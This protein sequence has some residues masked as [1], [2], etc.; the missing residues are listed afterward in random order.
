MFNVK[1][2][3]AILETE[4]D[5]IKNK[6]NILSRYFSYVQI[7][8][9]DGKY[10]SEKTWPY[11]E[12]D[13]D[14]NKLSKLGVGFEIDYMAMPNVDD[15]DKWIQVGA[16]R[17][18]LHANASSSNLDLVSTIRS[19]GAEAYLAFQVSDNVSEYSN[20]IKI[21]DGVQCMGIEKIGSQGQP[22]TE[23]VFHLIDTVRGVKQD[24]PISVDGAVSTENIESLI[25]YRVQQV[26]V[27]SALVSGDIESNIEKFK[28]FDN[29]LLG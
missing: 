12:S 6:V 21:C 25:K 13:N 24:I 28:K 9:V 19:K 2:I 18:I 7:D 26:A 29:I 16:S 5:E 27:G 8:V 17:I 23:K 14:F 3:P 4:F 15:I 11:S 10:L 22:F 1:I 20:V